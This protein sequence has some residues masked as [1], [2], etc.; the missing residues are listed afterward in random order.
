M[1]KRHFRTI[2]YRNIPYNHDWGV[3]CRY[4]AFQEEQYAGS[5]VQSADSFKLE[6]GKVGFFSEFTLSSA[7]C[8]RAELRGGDGCKACKDSADYCKACNGSAREPP[9]V[10]P[11][12]ILWF[13]FLA[14]ICC[15]T[16]FHWFLSSAYCCCCCPLSLQTR[17]IVT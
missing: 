6:G 2:I 9:C 16:A 3:F 14:L 13:V 1:N 7:C 15:L 12:R 5:A 17:S 10:V 8:C 4:S 11:Y